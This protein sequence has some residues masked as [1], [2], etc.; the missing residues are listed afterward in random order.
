MPPNRL[1]IVDGDDGVW[2]DIVNQ[3]L[4]K[5][6]Y[7]TGTDD[8][9]NGGHKTITIRPGTSAAGTAP[10]KFS[11][12]TLLS[13]AEAGAMEFNNDHL[14][15]TV[16]TDAVRKTI[17]MYDDSD[18]AT[19]DLF[20][21]DSSGNFTRLGVGS[22][23]DFL[24]VSSGLPAWGSG[25]TS[26][27]GNSGTVTL[28]KSDVGL[29]NV[30]NT[31]DAD[32]PVSNAAA[33]VM[34]ALTPV[35][36]RAYLRGWN[37]ALADRANNP[38]RVV[39]LGDSFFHLH[40]Q[41][42]ANRLNAMFNATAS[43]D[44]HRPGANLWQPW[45]TF[46]GTT[47]DSNHGL[48]SLGG[49]L[50]SS[51]EGTLTRTCDGFILSY[52]VQKTGGADLNIYID[53]VLQTTI[54]TTDADIS[55]SMESGRLWT[56]SALTYGSHTLKV[57]RSGT[58]TV[59][60][61]GAL[62]TNG[63]RTSGVQVWN[64]GHSGWW[65]SSFN[66]DESTYQAINTLDPALIIV[67]LGTNDWDYG[68]NDGN[69]TAQANF[70]SNL[71]TLVQRLKTDNPLA[72]I[73]MAAPYASADRSATHWQA[74]VDIIKVVARNESV[75]FIDVYESMGD[76]GDTYDDYNLGSTD[77]V[78]PT[79]KGGQMMATTI[80]S[81][82]V[83]AGI[84]NEVP[85]LKA[86]GSV[87][88]T[89]N[90]SSSG[91]IVA[92]SAVSLAL[93]ANGLMGYGNVFGYPAFLGYKVEGDASAEFAMY[94]GGLASLLG[95]PGLTML[96][97]EGGASS[98][99]TAFYRSAAGELTVGGANPST[100]GNIK[101]SLIRSNAGSPESVVTAPVGA[102]CHDTTNG[103]IY[104]KETGT[105]NTGWTA[106]GASLSSL[107]ITASATELNYSAGVT[108]A[109]QT[110][111]DGKTSKS[112][113]TTKG[114]IYAASAASTPARVAVGSNTNVL[115]ADSSATAGVSWQRPRVS[116][117]MATG[118][119]TET[120]PRWVSVGNL[121]ALTSG[122][123]LMCAID[124]M[125]GDVITSISF[126][127]R[128]TAGS[129]LTNQWFALFDANRVCLAVTNDDTT[130][131]WAVNAK[132]TLNLTSP[133]T[134][135]TT[136][137][138]YIGCMVAGTTVPTLAGVANATAILSGEAPILYGTSTSGLTTPFTVGNTAS[139]LSSSG[140]GMPWA[141]VS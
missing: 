132:K 4:E 6:H 53:N 92:G 74:F 82:I 118:A 114:D 97:G 99:D 24:K 69:A 28:T 70:E 44:F 12:G 94:S 122:T 102:I 134:I 141:Y 36:Y 109:I 5:E 75:G 31:S 131:A 25:V 73:M 135:S 66:G 45:T 22:N 106:I 133:Y 107:G 120:V 51:Q 79:T 17:A 23:G 86:D 40:G 41:K 81:S 93:G 126:K 128:S 33:A 14:Y 137:T 136:G 119:I 68:V 2:G 90:L 116:S 21:R 117:V 108:S 138:Y 32:K 100:L 110:Q 39:L 37:A 57:T 78:H 76:I 30:D 20:Y 13:S 63:N 96:F 103:I 27:N 29:N 50:S 98:V 52:D 123:L 3:F 111:L 84:D 64:A 83:T 54:N 91:S 77:Q 18:G 85:Y 42:I 115:V 88:V 61:G 104:V 124:L 9:D 43:S 95:Y 19:G 101:T 48:G 71:T 46:T 65:A 60:I 67:Q 55:G 139:A 89:G 38:A 112:T 62:Y 15:F 49:T 72:S 47:N 10:L 125:V 7:N 11:S 26:V 87:R 8:P 129:G 140:T 113:L 59:K 1:P 58:G 105:G 130:A 80:V 16:T 35:K 127:S 121:A 56:S 34:Y